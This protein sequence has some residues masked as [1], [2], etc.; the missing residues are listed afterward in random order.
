MTVAAIILGL[1]LV[2]A[3][4][5]IIRYEKELRRVAQFLRL[6]QRASNT[7]CK[8]Q[9]HTRGFHDA[10]NAINE[11]LSDRQD[12][13]IETARQQKELQM[14]L[15][16][17][18]HDI[19]TPLTG[20]RGYVQLMEIEEDA[21]KRAHYH[22]AVVRRLDDLKD[23]LDQLF[24]FTQVIDPEY[25]I[26]REQIDANRVLSDTL[27]SM[28]PLFAEV[29]VEPQLILEQEE[30][31]VLADEDALKRIFGN[32]TTNALRHGVGVFSVEQRGNTYTFS[33]EVAD[34]SSIDVDRLFDRF[35]KADATRG[36]EGGGLG[37]AIVSQ[38]AQSISAPLKAEVKGNA[39]QITITFAT[40]GGHQ[41]HRS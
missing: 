30:C 10:M 22:A 40:P 6:R 16:H 25:V 29:E 37:L 23:M 15:T 28:Y 21:A 24:L 4:V 38:L 36:G 18:S 39:L 9:L 11:E 19:R 17:L 31:V 14:G 27:L 41:E 12:E 32:L 33:N 3:L 20:A 7:S 1:L 35:Y 13:R 34:P 26:V 5:Q 8:T 2:V